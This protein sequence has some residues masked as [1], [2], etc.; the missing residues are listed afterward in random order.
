[1]SLLSPSLGLQVVS[2]GWGEGFLRFWWVHAIAL[3][4]LVPYPASECT[5]PRGNHRL[6]YPLG[7]TML[8]MKKWTLPI[9]YSHLLAS[10][11]AA[12]IA[13]AVAEFVMGLHLSAARMAMGII[14][15]PVLAPVSLVLAPIGAIVHHT[16]P[17]LHF[18][19]MAASYILAFTMA[20]VF[21]RRAKSS[22]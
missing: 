21:F 5:S 10:V 4:A 20:L 15:S 14:F 22:Q 2:A 13:M 6:F 12:I 19:A 3:C 7:D 17:P 11:I 8:L 9:L 1:M 16:D 18:M